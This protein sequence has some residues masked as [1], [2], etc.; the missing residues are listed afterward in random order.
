M[1]VGHN[2]NFVWNQDE[3]PQNSHYAK[4]FFYIS[5]A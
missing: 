1:S 5:Q 2:A 4:K 3:V